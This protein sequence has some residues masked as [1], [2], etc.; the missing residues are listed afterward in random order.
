M[1]KHITAFYLETLLLIVVLVAVI[2]TL[3]VV[4]GG[5]RAESVRA[6]RLNQA[7][8]LAE[9][10]AEAVAASD[11][12]EAVQRL[13]DEN[14][15]TRADGDTLTAFYDE[16]QVHITWVPEG[17]LVSSTVTVLWNDEEIYT[18]ETAVYTGG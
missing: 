7:V 11:S 9:N 3:T 12:L 5:A 15:N 6:S 18:L 13:L 8:I 16:F 10:A 14:G 4:F 2:L 1:R 17:A